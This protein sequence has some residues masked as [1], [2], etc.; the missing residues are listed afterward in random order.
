MKYK[1]ALA[2]LVVLAYLLLLM[3][4]GSCG[5]QKDPCEQKTEMEIW[6]MQHRADWIIIH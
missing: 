1:K 3:A 2:I 5:T 4:L 6:R